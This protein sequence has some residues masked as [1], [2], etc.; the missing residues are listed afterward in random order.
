MKAIASLSLCL[1]STV[2]QNKGLRIWS[3]ICKPIWPLPAHL[4]WRFILLLLDLPHKTEHIHMTVNLAAKLI[5]AC[6][7]RAEPG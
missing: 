5:Y 7:T 2:S 1:I 6:A 4:L 3:Q